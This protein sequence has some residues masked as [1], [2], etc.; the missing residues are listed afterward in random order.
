[1]GKEPAIEPK[2]SLDKGIKS[3]VLKLNKV[4]VAPAH[5]EHYS[6][7]SL[8][9]ICKLPIALLLNIFNCVKGRELIKLK[10]VGKLAQHKLAAG[11]L[12]LLVRYLQIEKDLLINLLYIIYRRKG[13][14][15]NLSQAL[16]I[17]TV[18]KQGCI[19]ALAISAGTTSLLKIGLHRIGK[20]IMHHKAHI[21]L[22]YAHTKG[23]S[24]NNNPY[25][26]LLPGI[27]TRAPHLLGEPRVIIAACYSIGREHLRE[28]L[29]P[30]TLPNIY[31]AAPLHTPAD[32]NHIA[33]LILHLAHNIREVGALKAGAENGR[34]AH[35][36]F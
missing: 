6:G 9:L 29:R 3:T 2:Q 10:M 12:A 26:V 4:E 30:L 22:I 25:A 23:I 17:G 7:R 27:L 31:N 18:P 36:Q 28:L 24:C 20:I 13:N 1:M 14:A 33:N 19:R 16:Q 21:R 15:V 34:A 35:L 32:P 11:I 8:N 5:L